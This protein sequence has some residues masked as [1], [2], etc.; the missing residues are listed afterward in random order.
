MKNNRDKVIYEV[1]RVTGVMMTMYGMLR[2]MGICNM[3]DD[4]K[5]G[6]LGGVVQ[7]AVDG[8]GRIVEMWDYDPEQD[9]GGG[10]E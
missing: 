1:A 10:D 8:L 9:E 2:D 3:V 5:V 7:G 4:G 6:V